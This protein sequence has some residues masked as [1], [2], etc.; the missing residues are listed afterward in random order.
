M[1]TKF[2]EAM[3]EFYHEV[4]G[5]LERLGENRLLQQLDELFIT[6]RCDCGEINC[7]TFKVEGS[8]S[9]LTQDEQADRGPYTKNSMDIDADNG[10]IVIDT[11]ALD[12][13]VLFEILNRPDVQ[14]RLEVLCR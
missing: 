14:H 11:D 8:R 2:K 9:P 4:K 6:G 12:R 13:I 7:S 3:P 10:M 5:L 1:K